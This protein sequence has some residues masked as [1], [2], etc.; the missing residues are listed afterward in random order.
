[1]ESTLRPGADLAPGPRTAAVA[2]FVVGVAGNEADL[3][4]DPWKESPGPGPASLAT[5]HSVP[6]GSSS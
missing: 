1:M 6:L 4:L 3:A 5:L 2:A